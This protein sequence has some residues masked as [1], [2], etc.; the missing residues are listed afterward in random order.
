[1][2]TIDT[3]PRKGISH[4]SIFEYWKDKAILESGDVV[5]GRNI[6]S[7]KYVPIT[8]DWGEPSCWACDKPIITNYEENSESA[9][10]LSK[11]W[12]DPK[13]K[14][15]LERCHIIPRTKGGADATSNMFLMC[16]SCHEKSPDTANARSFFRW[17]YDQRKTHSFGC[18]R[19]DIL[20]DKVKDRLIRR[21]YD[22]TPEELAKVIGDKNLAYDKMKEYLS[23]HIETHQFHYAESSMIEGFV[24]WLLHTYVET[25][26]EVG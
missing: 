26:L 23:G 7:D 11:I 22:I 5:D 8:I 18:L 17:V 13:V 20:R 4:F 24:D 14:K 9:E 15:H 10:D 19:L 16:P 25:C 6:S 1:M 12:N 2:A 21:G 3:N